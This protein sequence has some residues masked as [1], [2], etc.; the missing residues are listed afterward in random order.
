MADKLNEKLSGHQS[1]LSYAGPGRSKKDLQR[2]YHKAHRAGASAEIES[3]LAPMDVELPDRSI[4]DIVPVSKEE[5]EGYSGIADDPTSGVPSEKEAYLFDLAYDV[6]DGRVNMSSND[7]VDLD[8]HVVDQFGWSFSYSVSGHGA[9]LSAQASRDEFYDDYDDESVQEGHE[10]ELREA[11]RSIIKE[12]I[13]PEAG[14]YRKNRGWRDPGGQGVSAGHSYYTGQDMARN[15]ARESVE[16]AKEILRQGGWEGKGW[17]VAQRGLEWS[18][19]AASLM[20]ISNQ[21]LQSLFD[22]LSSV[23]KKIAHQYGRRGPLDTV[24][25][26]SDGKYIGFNVTMPNNDNP[27]KF[28][29][30]GGWS[31]GELYS[32]DASSGMTRFDGFGETALGFLSI[33]KDHVANLS[34]ASSDDDPDID[35][36]GGLDP[37]ELR[38]LAR[39]IESNAGSLSE[40]RWLKLAGILRD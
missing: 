19:P 20:T 30:S 17:A 6:A 40:N 13:L 26:Y 28:K 10:R 12:K 24:Q 29:W 3:Q 4:G 18:G 25:P 38:G 7:I 14:Y 36:D 15:S 2:A 23:K 9:D 33:V 39:D 34:G 1:E 31:N 11:I 37:D 5:W 16:K 22:A 35:N 8:A 21:E 27:H 32:P